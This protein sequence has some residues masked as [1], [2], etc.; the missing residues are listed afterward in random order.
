MRG[1]GKTRF[2]MRADYVGLGCGVWRPWPPTGWR[3][4]GRRVHVHGSGYGVAVHIAEGHVLHGIPVFIQ[5]VAHFDD[6]VEGVLLGLPDVPPDDLGVFEDRAC[7]EAVGLV[8]A[9]V[10]LALEE[11]GA[12]GR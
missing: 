5:E 10:E 3:E 8:E 2:R 11:E 1:H 4:A 12:G 7:C 9:V 6:G